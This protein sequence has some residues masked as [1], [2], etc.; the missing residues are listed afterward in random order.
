METAA[1]VSLRRSSARASSSRVVT[2]LSSS[3]RLCSHSPGH[4]VR[5]AQP[6]FG[7]LAPAVGKFGVIKVVPLFPCIDRCLAGRQ[8]VGI[9]PGVFVGFVMKI[10]FFSAHLK[11]AEVAVLYDFF[12]RHW[13]MVCCSAARS[14]E[15]VSGSVRSGF[16]FLKKEAAAKAPMQA[17]TKRA[18]TGILELIFRPVV[19]GGAS[20]EVCW[21]F[22]IASSSASRFPIVFFNAAISR[23]VL[24]AAFWYCPT[25]FLRDATSLRRASFSCCSNR[26]RSGPGSFLSGGRTVGRY[27]IV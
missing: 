26:K 24:P 25:C 4:Q 8:Q 12:L 18:I 22:R 15:A 2:L 19:R 7:S 21:L 16:R 9:A 3:A 20:Y 1:S 27:K 17:I 23:A 5:L 10:G 11:L 14:V 13:G 6:A